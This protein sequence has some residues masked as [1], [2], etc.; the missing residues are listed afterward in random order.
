VLDI[1]RYIEHCQNRGHTIATVNR[2]LAAIRSFYNFLDLMIENIPANPV[3]PKRHFIRQGRRLPRDVSDTDLQRF[4]AVI[5]SERDRAIFLLMLRCGLRIAEVH[6]LSLPDV[7]LQ[8]GGQSLP[9]LWL[10][11]KHGSQRV[12][13]LSDQALTALENW[14]R[15]RPMVTSQALFLNRFGRRLSISGI[16]KHLA[17]YRQQAGVH[18]TSHQFRHTLGRHLV[19]ARVPVTTIQRLF[20][21]V[22]LRTTELYLHISDAQVQA[23]Y[24]AAM[25][26]L[27]QRLEPAGG[28]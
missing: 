18:I 24:H 2:R 1:D 7:Y 26:E 23:D 12:V 15:V 16:Q 5:R 14:L 20:G 4:F 8:P 21:H 6:N 22:R 13:Y 19:E 3:I 25:A 9:R 17:R 27:A 11:G 10:Q 28:A